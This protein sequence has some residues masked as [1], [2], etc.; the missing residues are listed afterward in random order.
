M[1]LY[2]EEE[3]EIKEDIPFNILRTVIQF[4][5]WDAYTKA[6]GTQKKSPYYIAG[7]R[8]RCSRISQE[9]KT[10]EKACISKR[11]LPPAGRPF[12]RKPFSAQDTKQS[13]KGEVTWRSACEEQGELVPSEPLCLANGLSPKTLREDLVNRV[14]STILSSFCSTDPK[15][16]RLAESEVS[17]V[18]DPL[19]QPI[20]KRSQNE[21]GVVGTK[22]E[23]SN[24]KFE[25]MVNQMV[26]SA[27][28]N[29][30]QESSS[31]Q[32]I[33]MM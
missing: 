32:D 19:K 24:E 5:D 16:R 1:V 18:D 28:S 30:L 14:V 11:P 12:L 29:V 17:E 20:E 4:S 33:A 3:S 27:L 7:P 23:D 31:Q 26:H 2:S 21:M 13:S 6:E 9:T 15:H 25:E 22:E 8:L 10:K